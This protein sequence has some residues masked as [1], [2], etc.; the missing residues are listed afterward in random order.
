V[1]EHALSLGYEAQFLDLAINRG[2]MELANARKLIEGGKTT[3]S[4]LGCSSNQGEWPL[5][6]ACKESGVPTGM[7][8]DIGTLTKIDSMTPDDFP[9]RFMVS[10]KSCYEEV[11]QLGA[12]S[13]SVGVTGDCHLEVLSNQ[14]GLDESETVRNHY[15]FAADASVISFFGSPITQDTVDAVVSLSE[16]LPKI[17]IDHPEVIVRP[18]PRTRHMEVLELTCEPLPFI[19]FD[20]DN[21]ISNLALLS[22]SVFSLSMASTVT[23]ESLVLGTPSAFFQVGWDFDYLNHLYRNLVDVVRIRTEQHLHEF[24]AAVAR[25]GGPALTGN[26]ENHR[27]ALARTWKVVEELM[28]G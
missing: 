24:V 1:Y 16:S 26:V 19:H 12:D 23:L 6:R 10:N 28:A 17:G 3:A 15:G 18:H 20:G 5:M 21:T 2:P 27:G 25:K 11:I 9:S 13:A 8:V 7:V 14:V 4:I 22:A